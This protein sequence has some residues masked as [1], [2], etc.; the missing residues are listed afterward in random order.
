M[1][2]ARYAAAVV[3]FTLMTGVGADLLS[4]RAPGL[5]GPFLIAGVSGLLGSVTAASGRPRPA[6]WTMLTGAAAAAAAGVVLAPDGLDRGFVI[7]AGLL[8]AALL[9][10]FALL[11]T[12]RAKQ[13]RADRPG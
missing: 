13:A 9:A 11:A 8:V 4:R 3:V 10:I 5:A 12:P 1:R 7:G 2:L 6:R